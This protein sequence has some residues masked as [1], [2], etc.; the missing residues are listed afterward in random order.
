MWNIFNSFGVMK[1]LI[2]LLSIITLSCSSDHKYECNCKG[3][4][5]SYDNEYYYVDDLKINCETQ[6]PNKQDMYIGQGF[7][8]ECAVIDY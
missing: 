7:F 1:K 2:L 4:Y 8:V 6:K 5:I 3:K